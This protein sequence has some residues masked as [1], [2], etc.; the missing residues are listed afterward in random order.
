MHTKTIEGL[1]AAISP[2]QS[3]SVRMFVRRSRDTKAVRKREEAPYD[4]FPLL[5]HIFYT[6]FMKSCPL[7]MICAHDFTRMISP[8]TRDDTKTKEGRDG[9]LHAVERKHSTLSP[10]C[11]CGSYG[12]ASVPGELRSAGTLDESPRHAERRTLMHQAH[13][14]L[15]YRVQRSLP[16][17]S[18]LKIA[19]G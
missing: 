6:P 16:A 3:C 17:V 13:A 9:A 10:S 19:K 12:M 5:T 14:P 4:A 1:D 18:S 7:H 2:D 11:T 8:A 15:A